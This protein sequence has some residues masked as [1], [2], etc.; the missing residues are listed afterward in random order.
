MG[1]AKPPAAPGGKTVSAGARRPEWKVHDGW[2]GQD[3]PDEGVAEEDPGP[4]RARI[5]T[6]DLGNAR[7]LVEAHG[8][9]MRLVVDGVGT[10]WMIWAGDRWTADYGRQVHQWAHEVPELIRIDAEILHEMGDGSEAKKLTKHAMAS[11]SAR[12]QAA[13][14]KIAGELPGL[15]MRMSMLDADPWILNCKNGTLNLKTAEFF[16]H[17]REDMLTKICGASYQE[18]AA[19]PVWLRFL[20]T[21][22]GGDQEL[23]DYLQMVVGYALCGIN[24]EQCMWIFHGSG[25]N[26]K[27]TFMDTIMDM[28]GDYARRAASSTFMEKHNGSSSIPNDLAMLAGV[29]LTLASEPKKGGSLDEDVVKQSTGDA[30]ITARFLGREFFEFEP[31]FTLIMQTNNRPTIKGND[32]GIW[33][34]IR[35]V[36]FE[37]TIPDDAKDPDLRFKLAGELDGIFWWAVQGLA[38]WHSAGCRL[39]KPS[40]VMAATDD[41]REEMDTLNDFFEDRC[42]LQKAGDLPLT[43]DN[44]D[45]YASYAEWAEARKEYVLSQRKFSMVLK[46]RG[47][48]QDPN[49][50]DGRRWLGVEL[51]TRARTKTYGGG[52]R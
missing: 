25:S 47:F 32:H 18:G 22:M 20:D 11:E 12:A 6:T 30:R 14:V 48:K 19:C 42:R 9:D 37:V 1:S 52:F 40:R 10:G 2:G 35:L 44:G 51:T 31:Q 36:P 39:P 21:I 15:T 27:S 33:R 29:R 50:S 49:R 41:Y 16:P 26:G 23:V 24:T 46:E 45:M 38:R 28:F 5:H 43:A 34:R 8:A 7:R 17:R 4:A 13:M 3:P